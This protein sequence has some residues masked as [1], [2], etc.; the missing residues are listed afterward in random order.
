M[1]VK[2]H[3]SMLLVIVSTHAPSL[4]ALQAYTYYHDQVNSEQNDL[5]FCIV[6]LKFDGKQIK[7]CEFGEA[8]SS[9]FKGYDSLYGNEK[10]WKDF[11][12][13]T[14]Q[15]NLPTWYV[16]KGL[17]RTKNACHLALDYFADAGG[18]FSTSIHKIDPYQKTKVY[19]KNVN[20]G[21]IVVKSLGLKPGIIRSFKK[22]HPSLLILGDGT[23]E[24]VRTKAATN[25][26][27]QDNDLKDFKPRFNLYE[28]KYTPQ[29]AQTIIRDL[30]CNI[31]VIKP[32]N[33]SMG[34]GVIMVEKK[35]LDEALKTI[36][37]PSKVCNNTKYDHE[38]GYW[39]RDRNTTFI[40][41]EFVLSK[42]LVIENNVYDPTMRV[43]FALLNK[44]GQISIHYF[45]AYWK[46]PTMALNEHGNLTEKHKSHISGV[47]QR[48]S[49]AVA[50]EDFACTTNLLSRVLPK[51]YHKMLQKRFE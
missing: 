4:Q 26:F 18:N 14:T 8:L 2:K 42:P 50:P 46:L 43:I 33:S 19:K 23:N 11:W 38:Y 39:P 13:F 24:Y 36:L 29:L 45:G 6:D 32:I 47:G 30:G 49:A 40:V 25:I 27:F 22:K 44:D 51:L 17:P 21:L 20:S 3:L 34:N 16:D 48:S 37:V 10:I 31:F 1:N 28:K 12:D 7:I 9:Q 5:S 35:H 15:F 41:E